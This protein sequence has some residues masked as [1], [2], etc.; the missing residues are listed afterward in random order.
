MFTNKTSVSNGD[1][2]IYQRN[3]R[4]D[5]DRLVLPMNMILEQHHRD[6]QLNIRKREFFKNV[7]HVKFQI[8]QMEWDSY[9]F[10]V[11]VWYLLC[12]KVDKKIFF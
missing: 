10:L 12:A 6:L 1:V 4:R 8:L 11:V 5:D 9:V 7:F 2:I 3:E